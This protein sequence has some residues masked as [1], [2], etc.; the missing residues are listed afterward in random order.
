[1][2][3]S[4]SRETATVKPSTEPAKIPNMP[5]ASESVSNQQRYQ[6]RKKVIINMVKAQK[7]KKTTALKGKGVKSAID[8]EN[9]AAPCDATDDLSSRSW[10]PE[11]GL[12]HKEKEILLSPN[13]WLNDNI[14]N[15]AQ[16]LLKQANPSMPGLQDVSCGLVMSFDV[17]PGEFVQILHDGS[18]HWLTISTVAAQHPEVHVFDSLYHCLSTTAKM[19]VACLLYTEC[20]HIALSFKNTQMQSGTSACGLYAIAFAT[21]LIFEKQPGEFMFEQSKMRSHLLN[22]FESKCLTMFPIRKVRRDPEKVRSRE[23]IEIYCICRFPKFTNAD[24]IQCCTCKDWYHLNTCVTV[25]CEFIGTKLPWHCFK[26]K[27]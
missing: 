9:Y 8:L 3:S 10:I 19:Q 24:W 20:S 18:G 27:K 25:P 22:C 7:M 15:A 6:E 1:M 21:A 12:K 16:K 26:C 11:L 23:L 2:K 4:Q 5:N 13:E 14:I 17:E